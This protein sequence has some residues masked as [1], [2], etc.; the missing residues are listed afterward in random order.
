MSHLFYG[1]AS[2]I[3]GTWGF[4]HAGGMDEDLSVTHPNQQITRTYS[5]GIGPGARVFIPSDI[6]EGSRRKDKND[7][8]FLPQDAGPCYPTALKKKPKTC[9]IQ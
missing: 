1:I 8:I 3:I 7:I 2:V 4:V 6:N 5:V 9:Q